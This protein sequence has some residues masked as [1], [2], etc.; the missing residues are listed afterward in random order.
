MD[1]DSLRN[2]NGKSCFKYLHNI[3]AL[4]IAI[5]YNKYINPYIT[6]PL[7]QLINSSL[8]IL[9][10]EN[11]E[12]EPTLLT[13]IIDTSASMEPYR[14]TLSTALEQIIKR[15]TLFTII[16]VYSFSD[17]DD[18]EFPGG[19]KHIGNSQNPELPSDVRN[20]KCKGGG[21]GSEALKYAAKMATH[22]N[23][24]YHNCIPNDKKVLIII[25]DQT[26][27]EIS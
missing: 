18:E 14:D 7:V 19:F 25:T 17:F 4:I 20:I 24:E 22:R 27:H 12:I 6:V 1:P 21:A 3:Q 8:A 9:N 26:G 15:A 23:K 10:N 11:N 2:L 13:F 5:E 16:E